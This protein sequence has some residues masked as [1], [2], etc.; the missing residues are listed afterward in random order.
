M[1]TDNARVADPSPAE[2]AGDS[3]GQI[4]KRLINAT[5][6]KFFPASALPV[7]AGSAWGFYSAGTFEV[8]VFALALFATVCVHAACNV[9]NDVGDESGG[10]DKQNEDRIYPYTGGSRFIQTGIMSMGEMA[11]LGIS[12]LFLAALAGLG[13]IFIKGAMVLYFGL[14]GI[15]LGVLYSLGPV[16]LASL[17]IG[18]TAVAVA[19]GVVPIAGAAWLQGAA[20]DANLLIFSLPIGLWVADCCCRIHG[21]ARISRCAATSGARNSNHSAAACVQ[22]RTGHSTRHWRQSSYDQGHRRHTCHSYG[23]LHLVTRLRTVSTLVVTGPDF[24]YANI[25]KERARYPDFGKTPP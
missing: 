7:L 1:S 9:L 3:I 21:M 22:G 6:P 14:V 8:L 24:G 15:T 25:H 23:G 10:T 4:A 18:E 2:F 19:F 5:R 17:G 12:L 11:R 16:R 13:L 20:L